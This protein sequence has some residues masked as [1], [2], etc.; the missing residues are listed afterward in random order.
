MRGRDRGVY[1][2]ANDRYLEWT[3]ALLESIRAWNPDLPIRF[4]PFDDRCARTAA[5]AAR[6]RF[7]VEE[8][9]SLAWLDGVGR[10]LR[11]AGGGDGLPVGTYRRFACFWGAFDE[12]VFVD[13][14]VVVTCDL[15]RVIDSLDRTGADLSYMHAASLDVV[16]AD[17]AALPGTSTP[18]RVGINGGVWAARRGVVSEQGFRA[19][20]ARLEPHRQQIINSD[21][22]VLS[23]L[24]DSS[25]LAV[26][27]FDQPGAVDLGYP[28]GWLW[29]GDTWDGVPFSVER[30]AGLPV[31]RALGRDA[32][33]VHWA[34]CALTAGMAHRRLWREYRWRGGAPR[35]RLHRAV[36]AS[37]GWG[38]RVG[39]RARRA[40]GGG[41]LRRPPRWER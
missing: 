29:A 18:P 4:L 9:A 27:R 3:I 38:R 6:Y 17:A 11:P 22:T 12:F 10:R 31:L 19:V 20:A 30:R 23:Y 32:A 35:A 1:V 41:P 13:S 5:L 24:V 8:P 28:H 16:Y 34:G 21:Q 26:T 37:A 39:G 33:I 25:S 14:D 2:L 7:S 15:D 36:D 40:A